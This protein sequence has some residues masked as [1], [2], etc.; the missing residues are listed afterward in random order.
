MPF[1]LGFGE[2]LVVLVVALL[3]FGGRLPEVARSLGQGVRQ[4]KEGLKTGATDDEDE[5]EEA[6]KPAARTI[7]SSAVAKDE[8][9]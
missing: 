3:V 6:E 2:L 8:D 1:N 9:E 5:E 7:D 4:F